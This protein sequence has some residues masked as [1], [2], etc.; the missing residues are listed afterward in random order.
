MQHYFANF[1]I[2]GDPNAKGLPRWPA[3]KASAKKPKVM[4]IDVSSKAQNAK[5]DARFQFLDQNYEN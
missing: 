2:N 4:A 5:M 1:I 3:A